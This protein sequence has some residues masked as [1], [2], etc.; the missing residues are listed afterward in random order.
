ML[1]LQDIPAP[2]VEISS[3]TGSAPQTEDDDVV[4][5]GYSGGARTDRMV[6]G[7]AVKSANVLMKV[8]SAAMAPE[9]DEVTEEVSV[10]SDFS[11]TLA[12]EP[13]LRTDA[14]GKAELNFRTSDKLSTYV[15]ALYAHN[16][17]MQNALLRREM[18]VTRGPVVG[19]GDGLFGCGGARYRYVVFL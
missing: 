9:A 17:Q 12:F 10:R 8:E 18:V 16:P 3:V 2:W 7:M 5:I 4:L 6:R 1:T 15:V 19:R 11:S 13:F 14:E